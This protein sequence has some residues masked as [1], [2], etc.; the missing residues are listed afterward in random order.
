HAN[1]PSPTQDE[2]PA[3]VIPESLRKPAE[4]TPAAEVPAPAEAQAP[5][6]APARA[7]AAPPLAEAASPEDEG[8]SAPESAP[9]PIAPKQ[10]VEPIAPA[11]LPK[12]KLESIVESVGLQWVETTQRAE[13]T[14][15]PEEV[16]P[17]RARRVRK[18]RTVAS[19]EPL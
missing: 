7:E 13:P 11:S 12:E 18:P 5:A 4:E 1:G 19:A 14:P 8:D 10:A 9:A 15:Q 2:A 6:E 17:P 16:P 3:R